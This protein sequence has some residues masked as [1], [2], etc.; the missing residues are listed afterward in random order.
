MSRT[1]HRRSVFPTQPFPAHACRRARRAPAGLSKDE[2][3]VRFAVFTSDAI[4]MWATFHPYHGIAS[5][6]RYLKLRAYHAACIAQ[7]A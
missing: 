5:R 1:S 2:V 7:A 3:T 4:E 6:E